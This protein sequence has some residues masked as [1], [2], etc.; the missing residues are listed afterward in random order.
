MPWACKCGNLSSLSSWTVFLFDLSRFPARCKQFVVGLW[1]SAARRGAAR[2]LWCW[3]T[4]L[5]DSFTRFKKLK[6]WLF[7][8]PQGQSHSASHITATTR[9]PRWQKQW[10]DLACCCSLTPFCVT[11]LLLSVTF[12]AVF[13]QILAHDQKE[14]NNFDRFLS[15]Y[16]INYLYYSCVPSAAM[17]Q[18]VNKGGSLSQVAYD[19]ELEGLQCSCYEWSVADRDAEFRVSKS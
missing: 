3:L 18:I 5:E 17:L 13:Q 2:Q 16:S 19:P 12:P 9:E 1:P 4:A 15:H 14:F 7:L 11:K 10:L 8:S 6:V